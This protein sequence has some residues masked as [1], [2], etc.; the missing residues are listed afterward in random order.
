MKTPQRKIGKVGPLRLGESVWRVPDTF[1]PDFYRSK[2]GGNMAQ[3]KPICGVVV[4]IHPRGRF[5][6]VEFAGRSGAA[7]E[8]FW[9]LDR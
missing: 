4:Y 2:E 7:R 1:G 6:V 8:A 3:R 5:H 9:G